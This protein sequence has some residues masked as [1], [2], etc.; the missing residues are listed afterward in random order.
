MTRVGTEQN[1]REIFAKTLTKTIS[2][3]RKNSLRI[4]SKIAQKY[5]TFAF[6]ENLLHLLLNINYFIFHMVAAILNMN[7]S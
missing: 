6:R 1:C 4:K 5:R 3:F 2:V 7:R